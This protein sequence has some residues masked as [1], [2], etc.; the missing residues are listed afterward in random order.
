MSITF[1]RKFI[2]M[3]GTSRRPDATRPHMVPGV[4][5]SLVY[6]FTGQMFSG[7]V[8]S[9]NGSSAAEQ[10]HEGFSGSPTGNYSRPH[11]D[12]PAV[13]PTFAPHT[14]PRSTTY[15]GGGDWGETFSIPPRRLASGRIRASDE[16]HSQA[17]AQAPYPP[18]RSRGPV[19]AP[20]SYERRNE[21]N[22]VPPLDPRDHPLPRLRYSPTYS[23][24]PR[25][26]NNFPHL[27][28]MSA[29]SEDRSDDDEMPPLVYILDRST[30]QSQPGWHGGDAASPARQVNTMDNREGES[31]G[32]EMPP[33]VYAI[34]R[35]T[36][37]PARWA[38]RT[39]RTSAQPLSPGRHGGDAVNPARPVDTMHYN[40]PT[41]RQRGLSGP[42]SMS[43]RSTTNDTSPSIPQRRRT[44]HPLGER[45]APLH[46]FP[47]LDN[48]Q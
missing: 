44:V 35:S 6:D 21:S 8:N 33:L 5:G 28:G 11:R 24:P 25:S 7:R 2:Y 3:Q 39:R 1:T 16:S 45:S 18:R 36:A 34:N 10:M 46:A 20:P 27:G 22:N 4:T 9:Q 17:A 14:T 15:R 43:S 30:A 42:E 23:T 31:D 13:Q 48:S 40:T 41:V 19:S 38:R 29:N 47:E 32:D 12:S 26:G 37:Q